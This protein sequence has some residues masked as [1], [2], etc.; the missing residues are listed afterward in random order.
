VDLRREPPRPLDDTSNPDVLAAI[1]DTGAL[2]FS[3][4]RAHAYARSARD[5]RKALP[6]SDARDALETLAEY[7]ID[8]TR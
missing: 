3:R 1:H 7:A 8:R 2:D 4:E 6:R 5:A